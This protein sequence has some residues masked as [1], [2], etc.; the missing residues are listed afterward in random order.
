MKHRAYSAGHKT[1]CFSAS[2]LSLFALCAWRYALCKQMIWAQIL[3][4]FLGIWLMAA[5]AV[6]D[7]H[8]PGRINNLIVGPI[9]ATF[10]II[11]IWEVVRPL[12]KLN[13]AS[14]IWLVLAPLILNHQSMVPVINSFLV[15]IMMIGLALTSSRTSGKFA[16]GWRSLLD[17]P[18]NEPPS[19]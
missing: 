13:I 5:P 10:A 7:F 19:T 11:A 9:A 1:F 8:G 17:S 18:R 6:L 4:A 14:G 16:G 12:G 2:V 3:N 15:G